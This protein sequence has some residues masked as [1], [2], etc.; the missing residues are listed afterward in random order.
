[1]LKKKSPMVGLQIFGYTSQSTL[2]IQNFKIGQREDLEKMAFISPLVPKTKSKTTFHY[3]YT[4]LYEI[5]PQIYNIPPISGKNGH[6]KVFLKYFFTCKKGK[7][8]IV[9]LIYICTMKI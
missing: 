6:S 4:Q 5:Y 2:R 3:K 8:D 1:M 7:V 9:Q